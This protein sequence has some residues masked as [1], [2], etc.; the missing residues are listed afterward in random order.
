MSTN[1]LNILIVDSTNVDELAKE[2]R[3][4]FVPSSN[5]SKGAAP[6]KVFIVVQQEGHPD[7]LLISDC[8]SQAATTNIPM[9]LSSV[10][11]ILEQS[12]QSATCFYG[13]LPS[14]YL[15]AVLAGTYPSEDSTLVKD[16]Y[17]S[18]KHLANF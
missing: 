10:R 12:G 14:L 4:V 15:P 3:A 7:R 16:A 11:G 9:V 17:Q 18:G 5:Y 6:E 8:S 13:N 2:L 1:F